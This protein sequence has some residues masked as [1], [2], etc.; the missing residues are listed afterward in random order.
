MRVKV[1]HGRG[2]RLYFHDE[3]VREL[4]RREFLNV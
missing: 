1:A 3:R 4:A 2:R